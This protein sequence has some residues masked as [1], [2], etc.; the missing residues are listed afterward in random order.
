MSGRVASRDHSSF[1]RGSG[2]VY[3][4][5]LILLLALIG[6]GL[7]DGAVHSGCH[8]AAPAMNVLEIRVDPSLTYTQVLRELT[9]VGYQP[10]LECNLRL[11]AAGQ[12]TRQWL[13]QPVGQR[14]HFA[15]EHTMNVTYTPLADD[16]TDP[17]SHLASLPGVTILTWQQ[18]AVCRIGSTTTLASATPAPDAPTVFT[19]N[20]LNPVPYARVTFAST[21]DYDTALDA[22]SNLGVRLADYCY[23]TGLEAFN[24]GKTPWQP[25]GQ[26]SSFAS[27]YVLAVAPSPLTTAHT[28]L[29]QL[30]A[31]PDVTGV[32]ANYTPSC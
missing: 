23:E 8:C 3:L 30:S 19:S 27:T 4:A 2:R 9:D 31:L 20:E 28:W 24:H 18:S 5:S 22:I 12:N 14:E 1:R 16:A 26:E 21:T 10:T 17:W 7:G 32:Q 25:M 15:S 6:C 11:V 29:D 13:W